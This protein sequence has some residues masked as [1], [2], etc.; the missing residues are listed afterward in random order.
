MVSFLRNTQNRKNITIARKQIAFM[1][2]K[3]RFIIREPKKQQQVDQ[4]PGFMKKSS[5]GKL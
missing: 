1:T 2:K 4:S 5:I 3:K